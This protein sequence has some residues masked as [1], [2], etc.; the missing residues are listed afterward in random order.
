MPPEILIAV[1]MQ[2]RVW[3]MDGDGHGDRHA[4]SSSEMIH[5]AQ[6][7]SGTARSPIGAPDAAAASMPMT[8]LRPRCRVTVSL[9][10]GPGREVLDEVRQEPPARSTI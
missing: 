2:L 5:E 9:I 8:A 10:I 7:S 1:F 3:P 4:D 6:I